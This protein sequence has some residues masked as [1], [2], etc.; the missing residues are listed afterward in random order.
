MSDYEKD[1]YTCKYLKVDEHQE[2]C[3]QCFAYDAW[4][5]VEKDPE[6]IL[7]DWKRRMFD[8]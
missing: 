6:K 1:C 2:P 7:N 5:P 8:E 3:R 4:E